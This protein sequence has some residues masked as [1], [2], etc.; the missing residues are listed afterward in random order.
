MSGNASTND[1]LEKV[2]DLYKKYYLEYASYVILDR[3]VPAILDG[4]KPR[5]KGES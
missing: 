1:D 3:A 4:L 5:F 2:S